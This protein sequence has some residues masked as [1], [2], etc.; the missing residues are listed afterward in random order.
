[1]ISSWAG[2]LGAQPRVLPVDLVAGHPR[3]GRP[4][5]QRPA[6]H[7]PGQRGLGRERRAAGHSGGT[8]PGRHRPGRPRHHSGRAGRHGL[9]GQ[10]GRGHR[11]RAPRRRGGHR[12]RPAV[13]GAA[14]GAGWGTSL[15]A[16]LAA[17]CATA[18][19]AALR[20]GRYLPAAANQ[21]PGDQPAIP[22]EEPQRSSE[23]I[24]A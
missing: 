6:D 4:G 21:I 22:E 12:D 24:A 10:L 11:R 17:T 15:F 2:Y 19:A 16:A 23:T 20:F 8:A 1:M 9:G 5:I 13:G 18:A 7:R 14:L 3:R